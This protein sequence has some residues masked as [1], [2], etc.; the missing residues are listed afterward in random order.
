[1][2]A[3]TLLLA[4]SMSGGGRSNEGNLIQSN[5][6]QGYYN[7]SGILVDSADDSIF[8]CA[9]EAEVEQN[10]TY[11][12]VWADLSNKQLKGAYA[13]FFDKDGAYISNE[14][15]SGFAQ[16]PFSFIAPNGA[17]VA[18]IMFASNLDSTPI[19]PDDIGVPTLVEM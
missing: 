19:S 1:M 3:L 13:F 11:T 4:S 8:Y 5:V 12:C 17:T 9:T 15:S 16:I 6:K 18:K 10:S 2:D 7:K 14:P